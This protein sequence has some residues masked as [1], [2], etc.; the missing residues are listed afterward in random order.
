MKKRR[1]EKHDHEEDVVIESNF[2]ISTKKSRKQGKNVGTSKTKSAKIRGETEESKSALSTSVRIDSLQSIFANKDEADGAFTLFGGDALIET[3][4]E[5]VVSSS[6]APRTIETTQQ[7][8]REPLYFF[9][10]YD[11]PQK[12]AQ[13]LFPVSN[14]P[15]YHN[16]TEC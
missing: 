7:T 9:P 15:F 16:R 3:S 10:H 5:E 2:K 11:S 4:P 6:I 14:E 13:S 1:K 12:N 8:D